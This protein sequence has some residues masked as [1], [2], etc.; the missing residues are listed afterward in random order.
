MISLNEGI[1]EK[2]S[3]AQKLKGKLKAKIVQTS[4][5]KKVMS[6][7]EFKEYEEFRKN[8]T[9][10]KHDLKDHMHESQNPIIQGSVTLIVNRSEMML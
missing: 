10:F 4:V 9:Q 1:E 2:P 5:A 7:E 6:S 3:L 8:M